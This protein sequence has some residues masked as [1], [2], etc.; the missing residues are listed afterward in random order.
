MANLKTISESVIAKCLTHG[1]L[2]TRLQL[3]YKR[4][5]KKTLTLFLGGWS[6][7]GLKSLS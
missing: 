4:T 3:R 5:N 6:A 7:M 2:L 1:L